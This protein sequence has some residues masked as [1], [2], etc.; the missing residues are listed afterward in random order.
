MRLRIRPLHCRQG[1]EPT[2]ATLRGHRA[3]HSCGGRGRRGAGCIG[4]EVSR[5]WKVSH[6]NLDDLDLVDATPDAQEVAIER[7][8][9]N[10]LSVDGVD[11]RVICSVLVRC[12][13]A[14]TGCW[15][16][17]LP[18]SRSGKSSGRGAEVSLSSHRPVFVASTKGAQILGQGEAGTVD[19]L[20]SG[21]VEASNS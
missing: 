11:Q 14:P 19:V 3:L 4:V 13:V 12:V 7:R 10:V 16:S 15:L 21:H 8:R 18:L 17:C 9:M 5:R 1:F 20:K 6:A 2:R